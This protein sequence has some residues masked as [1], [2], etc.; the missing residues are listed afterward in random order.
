MFLFLSTLMCNYVPKLANAMEY[1]ARVS[2]SINWTLP[3]SSVQATSFESDRFQYVAFASRVYNFCVHVLSASPP[4][5]YR[6][7]SCRDWVWFFVVLWNSAK[8]ASPGS[9][10]HASKLKRKKTFRTSTSV[11]CVCSRKVK[12]NSSSCVFL[13]FLFF[14]YAHSPAFR[15]ASRLRALTRQK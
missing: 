4:W 2:L 5:K 9:M 13:L 11:T 1:V 12:H 8:C 15:F 14:F 7:W 3:E 10:E 6:W